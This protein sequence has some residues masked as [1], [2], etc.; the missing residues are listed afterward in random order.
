MSRF[1]RSRTQ[2]HATPTTPTT[3]K[4]AQLDASSPQSQ[5]LVQSPAAAPQVQPKVKSPIAPPQ[6]LPQAPK[7]QEP[8]PVV[9]ITAPA[10]AVAVSPVQVF[11]VV[12][13]ASTPVP[14]TAAAAPVVY[15]PPANPTA[16]SLERRC[17][18]ARPSSSR[19]NKKNRSGQQLTATKDLGRWKPIDDLTLII[20]IQQT[21]DLRTVLRGCKFS[22]KF[23]LPELQK[24]WYSLLYD[25]PISRIAFAAMKNLHPELVES[26][27]KK[28]LYNSQEEDL[29][30]TIKSVSVSRAVATKTRQYLMEA[31]PFSFQTDSPTIA[32]FQELFNKNASTFYP[33][34]TAKGL[35]NHWNLMKQYL[36][37]SDQN[38]SSQNTGSAFV[39]LPDGDTNIHF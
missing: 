37:L 38:A 14:S 12:S 30:A 1:A 22:C 17:S 35:L 34:R 13:T 10:A 23:T 11:P 29:I 32:T 33:S 18:K 21:N 5:Q 3:P 8:A 39:C 28:A 36:L 15:A 4:Q 16:A 31:S 9:Q 25:E 20:G 26:I 24:R 27:Q 19:R 2:S 6:I 7:F